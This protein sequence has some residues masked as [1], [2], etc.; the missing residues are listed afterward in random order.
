MAKF[1]VTVVDPKTGNPSKL[2]YDNVESTLSDETGLSVVQ[3]MSESIMAAR[4]PVART[5]KS[6]PVGKTSPRVLK[7]SL[8]LSCNYECEYCSQRFVPR[9]QETNP[10]DIQSFIDGLDSWIKEQP[11]KVEFWGG[12]P[13]VYIKTL[14]PL[15]EAIRAKYPLTQFTMI[16]NG[17]VLTPEI[18]DWIEK[19]DF[20]IG[21]SHD[22][23]GQAVRGPDPLAD[24][25]K[26]AAILDL[27][28]R[29]APKGK[30]SFNTMMNRNNPSRAAVQQFFVALTG[31]RFVRIG[32]GGI[33]D[34]YDE[35][36]VANSLQPDEFAAYRNLA[37]SEI[38]A[39]SAR[40]FG[41][42]AEKIMSFVNSLRTRRPI[43][44][45]GQ[46]CNM[47]KPD[48]LAVDL[49]GNVLTCQNVS[50]VG[51]A[52]NGESHLIGTV[53][54][55]D[56]VMLNTATHFAHRDEC[57]SCP[58][59]QICQGACMFLEGRLWDTTCNNAYSDAIPIFAAGIE[60]L[61][62][63]FPIHIEGQLRADRKDLFSNANSSPQSPSPKA[64]P[65]PVVAA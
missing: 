10:E 33:V 1:V 60:F 35:G 58:V 3:V 52:P 4:S 12:E 19:M 6:T 11:E 26:K 45:V 25:D 51:M 56:R 47:D 59:V 55:L 65:I 27:Y 42:L 14:R 8:G 15:A 30:M 48:I 32:E 2:F 40:N 16:T 18:N 57:L 13:L 23:P 37:F 41:V 21:L 62:G 7:I 38:R 61:T 9:S 5:S 64:F 34:A 49:R 31:D 43:S 53:H 29:L 36:G 44:S 46:R 22:G 28:A 63:L 39:G 17:S 24:P 50:A 54:D 20:S